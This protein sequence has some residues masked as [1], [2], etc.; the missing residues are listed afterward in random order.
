LG[1]ESRDAGPAGGLEELARLHRQEGDDRP[2]A[3][4]GYRGDAQAVLEGAAA[5]IDQPASGMK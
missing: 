5:D 4:D 1:S 2:Q 3:R